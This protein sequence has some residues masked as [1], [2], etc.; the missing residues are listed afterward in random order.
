MKRNGFKIRNKLISK[1]LEHMAKRKDAFYGIGTGVIKILSQ[2][3]KNFRPEKIE[4]ELIG[5]NMG[6]RID[7]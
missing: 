6:D 1:E 2:V 4:F 5:A 3:L 7:F